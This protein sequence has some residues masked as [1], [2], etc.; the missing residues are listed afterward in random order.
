MATKLYLTSLADKIIGGPSSTVSGLTDVLSGCPSDKWVLKN[1][2]DTTEGSETNSYCSTALEKVSSPGQYGLYAVFISNALAAQT[3][4][5]GQTVTFMIG[6]KDEVA[7]DV[8]A[9]YIYF[10]VW[11]SGS[12]NVKTFCNRSGTMGTE[13]STSKEFSSDSFSA[14]SGDLTALDNDR[15]VLEVWF[16]RLPFTPSSD[17][18]NPRL[19]YGGT[20]EGANGTAVGAGGAAS[21]IQ[22]GQTLSFLA[23]PTTASESY[24]FDSSISDTVTLPYMLDTS[25]SDVMIKPYD[26]T[27]LIC[28]TPI[29][30]YTF[31]SYIIKSFETY[32]F[33]SAILSSVN[34]SYTFD[35]AI[36][37]GKAYSFDCAIIDSNISDSYSFD[38]D[39]LSSD[40]LSYDFDT[41][42]V[43]SYD[44][45]YTFDCSILKGTNASYDFDNAIFQTKNLDYNFDTSLLIEYNKQYNFNGAIQSHES[46]LYY[47]NIA[48]KDLINK[49]YNVDSTIKIDNLNTS[50][51]FDSFV[52]PVADIIYFYPGTENVSKITDAKYDLS[53]VEIYKYNIDN[54]LDLILKP[55]EIN[56]NKGYTAINK[57]FPIKLKMHLTLLPGKL[58]SNFIT[59]FDN[60]PLENVIVKLYTN[61]M[62]QLLYTASTNRYGVFIMNP[63]P[64]DYMIEYEVSSPYF[65]VRGR[66]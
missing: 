35:C 23:E 19:Y 13:L 9:W 11:R 56:P 60:R 36:I 34:E 1:M 32:D 50:Y 64:G 45:T 43:F 61:D 8:G 53:N 30:S 17:D 6:A 47:Y 14:M 29:K 58:L 39:I 24:T 37:T 63:E 52:Y 40:A 41:Y 2:S 3:I 48:I 51:T 66:G 5:G 59:D 26:F 7:S 55:F 28:M 15:L 42:V 18:S 33:N 25:I 27:G 57:E 38:T 54:H 16:N 44:K 20:E 31:S 49:S 12:G 46:K 22:Y 21:Y 65:L 4:S 62:N 10:Y